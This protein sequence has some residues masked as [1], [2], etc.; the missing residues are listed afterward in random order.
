MDALQLFKK[1]L[2]TYDSKARTNDMFYYSL[3]YE[4]NY[5]LCN[6]IP[7]DPIS[8]NVIKFYQYRLADPVIIFTDTVDTD[9]KQADSSENEQPDTDMEQTG[10]ESFDEEPAE[11][12]EEEMAALLT[13]DI[14]NEGFGDHADQE[15]SGQGLADDMTGGDEQTDDAGMNDESGL[16]DDSEGIAEDWEAQAFDE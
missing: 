2:L 12:T 7:L 1:A 11:M 5:D 14:E 13:E 10:A 8:G 16:Y 3:P 6:S 15:G 9:Y 4:R